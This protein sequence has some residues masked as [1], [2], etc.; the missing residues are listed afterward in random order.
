MASNLSCVRVI[1]D[2]PLQWAG[3]TGMS[4][5]FRGTLPCRDCVMLGMESRALCVHTNTP[6]RYI[7]EVYFC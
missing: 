4:W 5:D 1:P 3:I 6:S 2:L 7:P